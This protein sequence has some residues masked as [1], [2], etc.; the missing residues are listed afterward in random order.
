MLRRGTMTISPAI[1]VALSLGV[2]FAGA[3]I[4]LAI[5]IKKN[6]I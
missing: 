5:A 4:C 1:L 6:V 2:G 3:A